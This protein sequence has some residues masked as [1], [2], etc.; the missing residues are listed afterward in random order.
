M[1]NIIYNGFV[2]SLLGVSDEPIEN[3]EKLVRCNIYIILSLPFDTMF[4]YINNNYISICGIIGLFFKCVLKENRLFLHMVVLSNKAFRIL[5]VPNM[6][7]AIRKNYSIDTS[8]SFIIDV[9]D[10]Q[11]LENNNIVQIVF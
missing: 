9:P 11:I 7:M 1:N 8:L 5:P 3:I 10:D 6:R 4:E 2:S